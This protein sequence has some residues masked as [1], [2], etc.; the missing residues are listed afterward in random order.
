MR[1]FLTL[2]LFFYILA[3][4]Q[5]SFL[6]SFNIFG[7][8]PNL[9]LISVILINLFERSTVPTQPKNYSGVFSAFAGGFFLDIFSAGLMGYWVLILLGLAIFIKIILRRHVRSPIR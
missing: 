8:I 5:T 6:V 1:R 2:V 4:L 9:I 7:V 3:L